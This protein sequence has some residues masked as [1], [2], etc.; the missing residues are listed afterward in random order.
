MRDKT[1]ADRI[2]KNFSKVK[3]KKAA[4][5][6]PKL[7]ARK[8]KAAGLK[9]DDRIPVSSII[10][11]L[12][13]AAVEKAKT[14][15]K[16]KAVEH[17]KSYKLI[18]EEKAADIGGYGAVSKGYGSA[19][20]ASYIDYGKLFSYL[21]KFKSQSAYE[22]MGNPLEALNKATESGSFVLADKDSMDKIGRYDKY[23]RSP[24]M[25]IQTMALSLVPVAGLSSAEWEEIKNLMRFD[26]VMYTLKSK[27]S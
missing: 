19:S 17:D 24:V 1:L 14:E 9:S 4:V 3:L 20:H 11:I 26:S 2:S 27:T 10:N 18:K 21:G 13:K 23:M 22:N 16:E 8:N 12:I 25:A 6:V 7:K 15:K 5:K